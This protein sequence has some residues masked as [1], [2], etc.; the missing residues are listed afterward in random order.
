[1]AKKKKLVDSGLPRL[2]FFWT[3]A[4]RAIRLGCLLLGEEEEKAEAPEEDGEDGESSPSFVS[5]VLNIIK[6]EQSILDRKK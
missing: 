5:S 3:V 1:M 2:H 6:T 4:S